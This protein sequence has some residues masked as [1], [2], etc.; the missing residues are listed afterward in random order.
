MIGKHVDVA[1][2]GLGAA[3]PY[4]FVPLVPDPLVT[5]VQR[6]IGWSTVSAAVGGW[7]VSLGSRGSTAHMYGTGLLMS[8]AADAVGKVMGAWAE[9]GGVGGRRHLFGSGGVP[10]LLEPGL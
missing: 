7:M 3:T 2:V 8:V 4:V 9:K 5:I 1:V 10:P 6:T